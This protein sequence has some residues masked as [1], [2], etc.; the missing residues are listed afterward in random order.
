MQRVDPIEIVSG[1]LILALGAFFFIGAAEYPMGTVGRMGPGFVPRALGG[2]SIVLGFLICLGSLRTSGALPRIS[3][4]AVASIT[5]SITLFA[6]MI[7][8]LG[9]VPAVFVA[10]TVAMLGNVDA[11]W[12]QIMLTSAA[13]S[14][15]CF[16][17]FIVLLG[18]PIPTLWTD[19]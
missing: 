19:T 3:W 12:R 18:L 1:L 13:I 10:S 17:L 9:L 7:E 4:R 8:R 5:V 15:I 14:A 2:I 16:V 6:F 11:K